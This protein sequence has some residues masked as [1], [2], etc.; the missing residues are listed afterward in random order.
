M[1]A[2]THTALASS[3]NLSRPQRPIR[4]AGLSSRPA[5]A[6]SRARLVVRAEGVH[7][8]FFSLKKLIKTV[9]IARNG[10]MASTCLQNS[11]G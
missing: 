9:F 7:L 6:L 2:L 10:Y 1:Q 11:F 5:P 8:P 3:F 4:H